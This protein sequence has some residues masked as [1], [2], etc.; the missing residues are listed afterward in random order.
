[1]S[2][3]NRQDCTLGRRVCDPRDTAETIHCLARHSA[4]PPQQLSGEAQMR[5]DAFLRKTEFFPGRPCSTPVSL[6]T[7][8]TNRLADTRAIASLARDCGGVF[9]P[10]PPVEALQGEAGLFEAVSTAIEE[11]GQDAA[12]IRKAIADGSISTDDR[13][14]CNREI[15]ETIAALCRLKGV[16][17]SMAAPDVAR[18]VRKDVQA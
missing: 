1:M 14:R 9:V 18:Q 4:V 17:T 11:V 8:L 16:L 6:L 3:E 7:Y 5:H 15:D 2:T 10:L 13:D 12:V